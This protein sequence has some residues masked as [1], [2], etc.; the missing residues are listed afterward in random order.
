[1]LMEPSCKTVARKLTTFASKYA[2]NIQYLRLDGHPSPTHLAPDA[3]P[4]Y[5]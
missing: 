4:T 3:S 5:R 1:L 2:T